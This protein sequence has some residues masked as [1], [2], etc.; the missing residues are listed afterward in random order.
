MDAPAAIPGAAL[1]E[2]LPLRLAGAFS[3]FCLPEI[4]I[5]FPYGVTRPLP[6]GAFSAKLIFLHSSADFVSR[7]DALRGLPEGRSFRA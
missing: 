1:W 6:A 7:W 3:S 2:L 4:S 5:F